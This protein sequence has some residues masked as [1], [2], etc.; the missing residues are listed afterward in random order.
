M[1]TQD[2]V[3]PLY[4]EAFTLLEQLAST[5][6]KDDIWRAAMV[7]AC[8]HVGAARQIHTALWMLGA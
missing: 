7:S 5:Y 3:E 6:G 8:A 4:G 1:T 2:E